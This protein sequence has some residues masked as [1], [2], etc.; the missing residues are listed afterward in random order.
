M[1]GMNMP[2]KRLPME[3]NSITNMTSWTWRETSVQVLR[4]AR[5]TLDVVRRVP[6][7]HCNACLSHMHT[8]QATTVA[9]YECGSGSMRWSGCGSMN[10]VRVVQ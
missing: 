7:C 4:A 8:R 10:E 3:I 5:V 6:V 1:G 9:G 2:R